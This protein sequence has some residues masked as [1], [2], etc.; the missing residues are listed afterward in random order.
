MQP[1]TQHV[2]AAT[3]TVRKWLHLYLEQRDYDAMAAM[4]HTNVTWLGTGLQ[5]VCRTRED[6]ARLMETERHALCEAF[7]ADG[8]WIQAETLTA[9]ETLVFGGLYL[10][11]QRENSVALPVRFSILCMPEDGALK[12][13]HIHMSTPSVLQEEYLALCGH[14]PQSAADSADTEEIWLTDTICGGILLCV[15]QADC[16]VRN[17]S[18]GFTKMTGY[19]LED[20]VTYPG[21]FPAGI[22]HPS[23]RA[24]ALREWHRRLAG[25][26]PEKRTYRLIC[27]D[28][29]TLWV[30]DKST[31][32]RTADGV[33][34]LRCVL[35][36]ITAQ[37]EREEA[38]RVSE[39]RYEIA[40]RASGITMFEYNVQ[41]GMLMLFEDAAA[42]YGLPA[43][44]QD[45]METMI[46]SG[47][48]EE[49]SVQAY[50]EMYENIRNGA[51]FAQ[52]YVQT[53]DV[54]GTL[55]DYEL[56]MT[57]V[58]DG[59]GRPV[60]AIGVRRN[61]AEILSLEK[62]REFAKNLFVGKTLLFEAD[63]TLDCFVEISP[64][65]MEVLPDGLNSRFSTCFEHLVR[66][67][68]T[69]EYCE[70][71]LENLALPRLEDMCNSGQNLLTFTYKRKE[72]DIALWYEGTISI[73]RGQHLS[74]LVVRFYHANINDKKLREQRAQEERSLYETMVSKAMI[75]YEAN[76][77]ENKFLTGHKSW[78]R[79]F[80][81]PPTENYNEMIERFSARAAHP[82]D[83]VRFRD[84]FRRENLLERY[85]AG[86][87]VMTHEYRKRDVTGQYRWVSV[88]V[89]LYDD[90]ETG[91]VKAFGYVEDIDTQK[92]AELELRYNAEHDTMTNLLNKATTEE[93]ITSFLQTAECCL[94]QHA[95]VI[96]DIDYFKTVNDSFGHLYGDHVIQELA[97]K[98]RA[99]FREDD[100]VGRI[101]GDEFCVFMKHISGDQAVEMKARQ[102]CETLS[103]AYEKEG[104]T[105]TVSAS[106]GAAVC[107][108]QG[109]T[110]ETLYEQA[111]SALYVAKNAGKNRYQM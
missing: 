6:A 27:K 57:N 104:K 45:G 111:D 20:L 82:D 56:S 50:R 23:D 85:R 98:I 46:R 97:Q 48:I 28:G 40:L 77:T 71:V 103:C 110:Y 12:L 60:R 86:E 39:M 42:R 54:D 9:G 95:F 33:D 52:S 21:G 62:E 72:G 66:H 78:N 15:P 14:L 16:P 102:L 100:I 17:V 106:V 41:N 49:K 43:I 75:A 99:L 68:V 92:R 7:V 3:L 87:R 38:N 101:G 2:D 34:Y 32:V 109:N 84:M 29:T 19:T 69:E 70:T 53:R 55:H 22:L 1:S 81:V 94:G 89:H 79:L 76:L 13:R 30:K 90:V 18:K 65:W 5:E 105:C 73:I 8:L 59:D 61:V 51:P 67:F 31:K 64:A 58:F 88:S 4:F 80:G 47:A 24:S 37:K 44:M 74:N 10:R 93:R 11:F 63:L 35:S 96:I 36:D 83:L 107:P 25:E 91:A 108:R 26:E